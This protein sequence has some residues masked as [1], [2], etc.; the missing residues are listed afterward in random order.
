MTKIHVQNQKELNKK[1]TK[2]K[3]SGKNQFHVITDFDQTLT[4]GFTKEKKANTSFGQIR[5][6]GYMPP[7]YLRKAYEMYNYYH[8]IE[9]SHKTP[10]KEKSEKMMEWWVKHLQLMIDFGLNKE[11]LDDIAKKKELQAREG[12]FELFTLLENNNIPL[13]IFSAG[14]GDVIHRYLEIQNKLTKNVH[15]ISNFYTFDEKGRV[16]GY[17]SNIVHSFNKNELEVKNTSYYHEVKEKK[18]VILMGDTLG[19]LSMAEGMEHDCIIKIG[20]LNEDKEELLKEYSNSYDIVILN[21]GTMG[22]II[23]LVQKVIG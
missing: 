18:N 4:K 11:I 20:F 14:L 6:G 1:I 22:Y 2:F 23:E 17:K 16:N 13:L 9:K 7:E 5:S 3:E 19:D 21:D 15:I 8:P 12:L 10:L